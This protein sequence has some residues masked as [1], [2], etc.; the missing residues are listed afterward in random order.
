M[1][2]EKEEE[3]VGG[4]KTVIS[5]KGSIMLSRLVKSPGEGSCWAE[6]T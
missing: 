5:T 2:F 4:M 6:M 1:G 3:K